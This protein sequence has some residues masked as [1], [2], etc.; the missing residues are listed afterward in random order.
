M[1]RLITYIIYLTLGIILVVL[2]VADAAAQKPVKYFQVDQCDTIQFAVVDWPGDRYTWDLYRDDSTLVNYATASGTVDPA[3]YFDDGMYGGAVVR[4]VNL[5]PGRYWLRVMVYDEVL[6]TN[7]L[8]VF[9]MDVLENLPEAIIEGDS[10]CI[11]DPPIVKII[12]T[13]TGP[14]DVIYTYGD[15]SNAVNLY[16][17]AE[18][19]YIIPAPMLPV[20]KT[21]FWIMEVSDDCTVNSYVV[22]PTKVG[23]LIYP[24]PTS[25]KIYLKE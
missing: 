9:L 8:M 16:G 5:E 11:G 15:E 19:E 20:G 24:K 22:N 10:T 7:N 23:V 21:D 25:S 3:V 1:K 13:G 18:Q 6:C 17:I 2:T 12:F 14:W 4:V